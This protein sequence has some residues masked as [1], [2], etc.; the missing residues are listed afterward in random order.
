MS[1]RTDYLN[2]MLMR[3]TAEHDRLSRRI[4]SLKRSIAQEQAQR[5]DMRGEKYNKK[6]NLK[7]GQSRTAP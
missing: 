6:Q 1:R 3:T 4:K 5:I 2:T 7:K